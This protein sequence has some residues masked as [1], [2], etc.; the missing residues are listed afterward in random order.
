MQIL[1]NLGK[2]RSLLNAKSLL[3]DFPAKECHR[4]WPAEQG[5]TSLR[6]GPAL[7]SPPPASLAISGW[8][9]RMGEGTALPS[10]AAQHGFCRGPSHSDTAESQKNGDV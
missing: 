2:E 10:L 1:G 8:H 6:G 9:P 3:S 5:C 7:L 4:H